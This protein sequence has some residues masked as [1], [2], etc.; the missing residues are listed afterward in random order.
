M[1]RPPSLAIASL[2]RLPSSHRFAPDTRTRNALTALRRGQVSRSASVSARRSN[3]ARRNKALRELAR[4][5]AQTAPVPASAPFVGQ[6]P[7]LGSVE[8]SLHE[9]PARATR[10][11]AARGSIS[12]T[13]D[14]AASSLRPYV[15]IHQYAISAS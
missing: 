11:P 6:K 1:P 2:H 9:T 10:E 13:A 15:R 7:E 8:S 4:F 12:W 5:P 14:F 3:V